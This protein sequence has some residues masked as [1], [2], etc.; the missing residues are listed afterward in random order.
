LWGNLR[1]G[2]EIEDPGV[3]ERIILKWSFKKWN[4]LDQYGSGQGQMS[5]PCECGNGP[6]GF[7]KFRVFLD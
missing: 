5:G 6:S 7:L 4:G 1:E 3:G 2:D